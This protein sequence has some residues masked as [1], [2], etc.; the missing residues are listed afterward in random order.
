MVAPVAMEVPEGPL[1][2][3]GNTTTLR[4]VTTPPMGTEHLLLPR[5]FTGDQTQSV[6]KDTLAGVA[7]T[8]SWVTMTHGR[9]ERITAPMVEPL[10]A[11]NPTSA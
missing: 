10:S 6:D 9:Q 7:T 11:G 4:W 2:S 1:T 5:A 3:T 8:A